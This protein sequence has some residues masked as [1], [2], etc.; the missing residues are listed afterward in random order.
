MFC[1]ALANFIASASVS[2]AGMVQDSENVDCL[3]ANLTVCPEWR[4][5]CPPRYSPM[6]LDRNW[7]NRLLF[8]L[9]LVEFEDIV[10]SFSGAQYGRE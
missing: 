7:L 10:F 2:G 9:F 5:A 6:L 3:G 1:A 8:L 4:S